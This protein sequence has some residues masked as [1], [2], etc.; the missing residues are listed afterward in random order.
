MKIELN[1]ITVAELA[2]GYVDDNEEGVVG[3]GGRLDIRPKYQ[4]NFIYKAAQR[5][6]VIDTVRKGY[7]LNVMYWAVRADGDYEIIDGQQRTISIC[8]YVTGMFSYQNLYFKNLP[9]DKQQQILNYK[10]WVYFCGGNDSEKLEWF[11]TINIAGAELTHQELRNAVYAGSWVTDAKRYFSR[12]GCQAVNIGAP[13]L[14]GDANRQ[15]YLATAIKWIADNENKTIENYMGAH[16]HEQNAGMLWRYF[17]DV[18][19]WVQGTFTRPRKFMRGVNWG[20]LH[21][22]FKDAKLDTAAIE[23]ETAKLILDDDVTNNRGI[24]PYILTRD[25]KHLNIRAFT[26]AMKQ[27]VY[28]KQ[29]GICV[30]CGD[31]FDIANMDADHITPWSQGGKTN[32]DNCQLL[33]RGCNRRKGAK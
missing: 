2:D 23:K 26:E 25:E 30:K 29:N 1:G 6:A 12:R 19:T 21:N 32:M 17:Q 15:D 3:Y 31:K 18:I 4:R 24:Y 5:D 11:K 7:P 20:A 14:T 10:L 16:Q 9:K 27:K 22:Q 28:A 33:C 13:Y 8:Q